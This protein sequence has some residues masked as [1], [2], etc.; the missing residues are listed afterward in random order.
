MASFEGFPS[1]TKSLP[2]PSLLLGSLLE[3]IDD[4]AELKCTLRFLWYAAQVAGSPKWVLADAL[5]ADG[6]LVA[7]LGSP[8]AIREGLRHA[9][10]R[11]TLLSVGGKL[12]LH[13]PE[14]ERDAEQL[15]PA[16]A[17]TAPNWQRRAEQPNVYSLYEANIGLL[18]P[19]VS[20]QLRDAEQEY[21]A[22]WIKA[23][24]REAVERNVRN[25]RYVAVILERWAT[26]GRVGDGERGASKRG[27][28]RRHPQAA[29]AAEYLRQR[30]AAE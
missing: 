8:Q 24:I 17:A 28:S 26:E 20:D 3:E 15:S 9:I 6:V 27:E 30:R 18:T 22:E 25:W 23:A 16:P 1:G 10:E 4:L 29:S 11:G 2:V 5:E 19:M 7:A 13:T 12:L 14:N 21:P